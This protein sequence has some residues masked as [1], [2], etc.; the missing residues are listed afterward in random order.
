M[1]LGEFAGG[2]DEWILYVGAALMIY[3]IY[4]GVIDAWQQL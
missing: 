3:L 1:T 2:L 4:V